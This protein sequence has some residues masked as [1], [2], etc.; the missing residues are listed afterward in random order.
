MLPHNKTKDGWFKVA[1]KPTLVYPVT[2]EDLP[3]NDRHPQ[4]YK[5]IKW[6]PIGILDFRRF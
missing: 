6:N 2:I 5:K 3:G 1:R 4:G